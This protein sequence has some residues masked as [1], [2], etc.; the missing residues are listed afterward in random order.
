VQWL[1]AVA[2][3]LASVFNGP[4]ALASGHG[5]HSP[6]AVLA[7]NTHAL[8]ASIT[9]AN[10]APVQSLIYMALTQAAVYNAVVA[11]VGRYEPYKQEQVE[12]QP[13]AS[14]DAAVA[15]A[16]HAVLVHYIPVPQAVSYLD[17]RYA[18]DLAAIPA[19]PTPQPKQPRMDRGI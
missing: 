17:A 10:H 4:V 15:T 13:W 14:V 18:A 11:I 6:D 12:R 5:Q 8:Y 2:M 1:V 16:A 9:V 7:W 3:L 19:G